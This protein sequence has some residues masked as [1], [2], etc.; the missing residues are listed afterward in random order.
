MSASLLTNSQIVKAHDRDRYIA[1]LFAPETNRD[2]LFTLYAFDAEVSRI[3]SVISDPLP[4]EIR[5]QWW[6]EVIYGER[7][8]EA[9]G[10]MLAG[11]MCELIAKYALPLRSFDA[12]FDAKIFEFYNDAFPD[13]LALEAWCGETTSAV[14]QMAVLILDKDAAKISADA[15]GHGGVAAAIAK[16][17]QRLAHTRGKGR[18][19]VPVDILAAC[20]LD[21][22]GFL[23][24]DDKARIKNASDALCELGLSHYA[25][26]REAAKHL[27]P[28]A[29]PAFLPVANAKPALD[30]AA[31]ASMH[32]AFAPLELSAL[33]TLFGVT[34]AALS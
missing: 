21:R 32:P 18:C 2:D 12:Y 4:G 30:K 6:R 34:K 22:E 33:R 7:S 11:S 8:G 10:N 15:S 17:I 3:R 14:L 27:P 19:F 9:K 5:L 24:G 1:T 25:K 20:G 13:T 28:T 23:R 26:F 16:I 29:K 31:K